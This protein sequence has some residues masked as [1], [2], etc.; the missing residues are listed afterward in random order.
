M[1]VFAL[2]FM[3]SDTQFGYE[4]PC[5]VVVR[6]EQLKLFKWVA[7]FSAGCC[8]CVIFVVCVHGLMRGRRCGGVISDDRLSFLPA[9]TVQSCHEYTG[10]GTPS[11]PCQVPGNPTPPLMKCAIP[12]HE[13]P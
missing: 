1:L 2:Q 12:R 4:P 10:V 11:V 9:D 7:Y 5:M 8:C 3:T 13:W 6:R